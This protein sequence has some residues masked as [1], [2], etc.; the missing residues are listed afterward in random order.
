[1]TNRISSAEKL[2]SEIGNIDDVYLDEAIN[3]RAR[4]K[5]PKFILLAACIAVSLLVV[6]VSCV[7]LMHVFDKTSN[8]K[9]F[10]EADKPTLDSVIMS[11]VAS[12]KLTK[13][14]ADELNFRDG[15]NYI[16][17][18][19]DSGEYYSGKNLTYRQK[20]N[21][22]RNFGQGENVG[23]ELPKFECKVWI[24]LDDG[25]VVTP[26]LKASVGNVGFDLFDYNA[27]IYPT[28]DFV[29]V[30]SEIIS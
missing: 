23:D 19:T 16:V 9:N 28:E 3:Y 22:T 25:C 7:G 14:S 12:G 10:H 24:V 21:L 18:Q 27:E 5:T 2:L 17:I 26:Y 8:D 1:M 11:A 29:S 20:V 30:I 15:E 6:A 13:L 4:R